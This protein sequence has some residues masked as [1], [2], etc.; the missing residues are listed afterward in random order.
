MGLY[1]NLPILE[2]CVSADFGICVGPEIIPCGYRGSDIRQI[3]P[4][5]G[6]SE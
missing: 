1:G 2:I 3:I 4:T 5:N 6:C